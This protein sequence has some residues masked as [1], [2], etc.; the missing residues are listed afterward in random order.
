MIGVLRAFPSELGVAPDFEVMDGDGAA[1]SDLRLRVL[2]RLFNPSALEA[3]ARAAFLDAYKRATFGREEKE[4]F[5]QL[6][7]F[8]QLLL[9]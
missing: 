5:A 3:S 4:A 9:T 6:D 8:I 7:E 1:A 2:Q